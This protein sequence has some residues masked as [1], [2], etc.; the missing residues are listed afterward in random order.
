MK[1]DVIIP[2]YRPD[3]EFGELLRRLEAQ[4]VRPDRILV[5]NTEKQYWDPSWEELAS[6][7]EVRHIQKLY[8]M[9]FTMSIITILKKSTIMPF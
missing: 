4:T 8:M 1:I 2:A 9:Q 6:N 5:I 7:L 3:P